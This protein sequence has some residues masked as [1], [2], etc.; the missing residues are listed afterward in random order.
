MPT[1]D[2]TYE[3]RRKGE[4]VTAYRHLQ[5]RLYRFADIAANSRLQMTTSSTDI[6][7]SNRL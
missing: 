1:P 7:W 4:H 3:W 6:P 5:V 2:S